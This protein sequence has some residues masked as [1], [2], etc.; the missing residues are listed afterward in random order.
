M[1]SVLGREHELD[2]TCRGDKIFVDNFQVFANYFLAL[3]KEHS[4]GDQA[5][6]KRYEKPHLK[7]K[8]DGWNGGKKREK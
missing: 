8:A 5:D 3:V 1:F 4:T 2:S 7:I 6:G